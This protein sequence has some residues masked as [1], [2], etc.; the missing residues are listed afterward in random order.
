MVNKLELLKK[1]TKEDLEFYKKLI[2][3]F[4]VIGVSEDDLFNMVALSKQANEL[5]DNNNKFAEDIS[6]IVNRITL[7]EDGKTK[8]NTKNELTELNTPVGSFF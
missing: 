4:E 5:I 6:A 1:L 2:S 3:F 7:L 8:A